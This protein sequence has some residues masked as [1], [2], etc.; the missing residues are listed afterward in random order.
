MLGLGFRAFLFHLPGFRR[1]SSV[2]PGPQNF[3]LQL[4]GGLGFLSFKGFTVL[5]LRGVFVLDF[6]FLD[7]RILCWGFVGALGLWLSMLNVRA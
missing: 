2:V 6:Q 1:V 4:K 5:G 3:G 7:L